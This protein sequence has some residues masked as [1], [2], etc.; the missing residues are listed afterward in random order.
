LNDN[1]HTWAEE[2]TAH[3][4]TDEALTRIKVPDHVNTAAGTVMNPLTKDVFELT[5][6]G[7]RSLEMWMYKIFGSGLIFD[8]R[9]DRREKELMGEALL[10]EL[11]N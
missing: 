9:K 5:A 2:L 4:F 6:E 8:K 10:D 7:Q 1:A 11:H 3:G